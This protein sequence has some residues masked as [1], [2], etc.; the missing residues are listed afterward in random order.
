MVTT[1]TPDVTA[2]TVRPLDP[3]DADGAD[4][5]F[6][7]AFGTFL[8]LPEPRTFM[9]DAGYV[10]TRLRMAP[11]AGLGAYLGG[12]LVGSNFV[13]DWG[14][15]GFFGPLSVRPD[16]WDRG[17]AQALLRE[18]MELFSAWG[19][20]HVGLFTWPNSPKHVALYQRFGFWPRF[21]T[22]VMSRPVEAPP[23]TAVAAT[24]F[25]TLPTARHAEVL[26]GV[27]EL[28]GRIYDGLDVRREIQA[29][30]NQGLG[31]TLLVDDGAG[32]AA[33]AVCH[34]GPGTEA[35][36][37]ALFVKFGAVRPGPGAP[38]AFQE[39]LRACDTV[40]A[41]RGAGRVVAGVNT[42]CH[43]A[44]R[45]LL[46]DGFRTDLLGVAMQRSNDAGYNRRG[47]FVVADW[48]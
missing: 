45:Q 37:G 34:I 46:E 9:G 16:V 32:I 25:T 7:D 10:H 48:R 31:E 6:R 19:T 47:V 36:S 28:T 29:V 4:A 20:R 23:D 35:G 1:A 21:L 12:E 15:V 33:V 30:Q 40:A 26:D 2:V 8:G 24:E 27:A 41:N 42:A 17:I 3:R 39:L 5:I 13:A 22:A 44:Y 11:E 38:R 43:E 18:T 14:S